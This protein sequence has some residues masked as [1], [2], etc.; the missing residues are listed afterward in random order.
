M[1]HVVCVRFKPGTTE[2]Q[3]GEVQSA[4]A[5]LPRK[6]GG[7]TGFE[8]GV[9]VSVENKGKGFTHIWV[10]TFESERMR[11]SYLAHPEHKAFSR[12]LATVREDVLVFDYL[13]TED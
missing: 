13:P 7:I 10:L 1:K 9:N 6:I 2:K 5:R 3:I 4:F 8:A 11:D 12:L